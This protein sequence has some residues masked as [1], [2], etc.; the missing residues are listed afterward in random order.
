MESK[1]VYI[2]YLDDKWV[3]NDVFG[4]EIISEG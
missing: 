1:G 4:A 3:K 2:I